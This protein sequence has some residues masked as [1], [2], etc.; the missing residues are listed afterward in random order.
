[1]VLAT[2]VWGAS[3]ARYCGQVTTQVEWMLTAALNVSEWLIAAALLVWA[4]FVLVQIVALVAR[5]VAGPRVRHC[6]QGVAADVT[7]SRSSARAAC[8]WC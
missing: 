4:V 7:A 6:G 2:V 8:S 5:T 1:M 3:T